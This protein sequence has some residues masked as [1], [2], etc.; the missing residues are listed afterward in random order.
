MND[1]QRTAIERACERLVIRYTHSIDLRNRAGL[2]TVF[3]DDATIE[4]GGQV[5]SGRDVIAGPPGGPRRLMRHV[6]TNI[7]ID[8]LDDQ[9]ATGLAYLVAYVQG[10]NDTELRLPSVVGEYSD[11]FTLTEE[12]WRITKRIFHPTL[13]GALAN[14]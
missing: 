7:L 1:E 6:C 2:E 3:S 8:V 10:E 13:L 14:S 4:I 12:G 9:H 11:E 5:R